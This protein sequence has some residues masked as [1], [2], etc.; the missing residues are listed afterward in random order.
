M[1][2]PHHD[3]FISKSTT[4]GLAEYVLTPVCFALD[5]GGGRIIYGS[6]LPETVSYRLQKAI[7]LSRVI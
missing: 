5:V 1:A 6:R 4:D 3:F 7:G 2:S